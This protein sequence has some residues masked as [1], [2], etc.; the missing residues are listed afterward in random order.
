[1][2]DRREV[3]GSML[4]IF[5]GIAAPEPVRDALWTPRPPDMRH[6]FAIPPG[7]HWE[8]G[9]T[10]SFQ[11]TPHHLIMSRGARDQYVKVMNEILEVWIDA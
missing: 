11:V 10:L 3:V 2:M 7:I 9:G 1:M 6:F 5:C 4:A 8:N